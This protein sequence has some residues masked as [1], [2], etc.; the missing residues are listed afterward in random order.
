MSHM[1]DDN[2]RIAEYIISLNVI[3]IAIFIVT[4]RRVRN[5]FL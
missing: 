1:Y 3:N 5:I 2:K 4:K